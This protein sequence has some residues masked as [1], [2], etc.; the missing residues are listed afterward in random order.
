M[1]SSNWFFLTCLQI[2]QDAGQVVW[3]SHLFQNFPQFVVIH[4]VKGFGMVN[5][6]DVFMELSCFFDDPTDVG[7]LISGSSAF[8]FFPF[9]FI[10]WRIIVLYYCTGFCH[11]ATQ[12]S[13]KYTFALSLLNLPP[14]HTPPHNSRLSEGTGSGPLCYRPTS[15]LF[16]INNIKFVCFVTCMFQRYSINSSHPSFPHCVH[17]SVLHVCVSFPVLQIGSWI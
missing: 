11:T 10:C 15:D 13:H 17:K 16:C 7:N 2:A 6:A 8:S 12:I 3:Y 5:Q 4:T 1:S 9:I 14:I